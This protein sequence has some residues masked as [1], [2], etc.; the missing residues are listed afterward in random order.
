[1]RFLFL[2]QYFPPDPAPTGIQLAELAADLRA[3]GHRVDFV[4]SGQEYRGGAK[5][6][7]GRLWREFKA[8]G[9]ILAAGLLGPRPDVVLSASSPPCL[10]V[11]ATVI[12][13]LH[14]AR[15]VH[16]LMDMYPELAVALGEVKPGPLP[17][18]I[19]A[20]MSWGYRS[21]ALLVALDGDMAARLK[22][23]YGVASETI[24]P[25]VSEPML[26]SAENAAQTPESPWTW[27]YSGNL[28]RAHE[29]ETILRAQALVEKSGAPLRLRFQGGGPSWDPA[30]LLAR[31]LGL[32]HC[33]WEG[34]IEEAGLAQ[35]LLRCNALVVTQKPET[36]GYLWPSK[37][38]FAMNLPRPILWIGPTSGAIARSLGAFPGAGIFSPG[39]AEGVAAWL[40]A[41]AGWG[42][43]AAPYE[44]GRQYRSEAL[45]LWARLLEALQAHRRSV[46]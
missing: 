8:L 7:G 43:S 37:L 25:W 16:W 9:S 24:H 28:G 45:V 2:N 17:S 27:I 31:E 13:R 4:A 44:E 39:D 10:L 20:L 33:E 42:A 18:V 34:Y 38:A 29:W 5:R 40:L 6:K 41:T 36:Q 12:A 19:Q 32:R 26:A 30:Q 15:S 46:R 11:A 1:M 35:S 21:A 14:R 23:A 3:R 22:T